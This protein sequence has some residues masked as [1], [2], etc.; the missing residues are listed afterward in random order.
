MPEEQLHVKRTEGLPPGSLGPLLNKSLFVA[1]RVTGHFPELGLFWMDKKSQA[2][3]AWNSCSS[4]I[5]VRHVV[6]HVTSTR[7]PG[8]PP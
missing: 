1:D 2:I 8:P 6:K 7:T 5:R 4:Y 3:H